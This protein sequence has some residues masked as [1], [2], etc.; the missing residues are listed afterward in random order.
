MAGRASAVL[1]VFVLLASSSGGT[2]APRNVLVHDCAGSCA[3]L[4]AFVADFRVEYPDA[5]VETVRPNEYGKA[6]SFYE[7]DFVFVGAG[8]DGCGNQNEPAFIHELRLAA[9]RFKRHS[10]LVVLIADDHDYVCEDRPISR[11]DVDGVVDFAASV[12]ER[13]T[14]A[15]T[16]GYFGPSVF[17]T[18]T[19]GATE[20]SPF[21][22][23]AL[24]FVEAN[25]HA[26]RPWR[27]RLA[28]I[29]YR[30]KTTPWKAFERGFVAAMKHLEAFY[31][32]SWEN[33]DAYEGVQLANVD[34]DRFN[35]DFDLIFIKSNWG[36]TVDRFVRM[37]FGN[38][39][40]PKAL[41]I[42][43]VA[44]PPEDDDGLFFY[45]TLYYETNWYWPK[46]KRHPRTKKA[47]GIDT[48]VMRPIPHV[49]Q[50]KTIDSLFIG[51][52]ANYKRPW[53]F[54]LH[55]ARRH[56]ADTTP[57]PKLVAIGKL[58]GMPESND[59]VN[60]FKYRG[61]EVR[62]EV[63][64]HELAVLINRAK[65][66]HIPS[67]VLGGGERAVLEARACGVPVKIEE[68]NVK[69][70]ELLEGPI[71]SE[72]QYA[73]A[74]HEGISGLMAFG[75]AKATIDIVELS[76]DTRQYTPGDALLITVRTTNF[77][78]G[79]DGRWCCTVENVRSHDKESTCFTSR[80]G[81]TEAI[82]V[83]HRFAG[84]LRLSCSL[85]SHVYD[86]DFVRGKQ[87]ISLREK[88]VERQS[89]SQIDA[90]HEQIPP[91]RV[92]IIFDSKSRD[93]AEDRASAL[94]GTIQRTLSA[95]GF[96]VALHD[97]DGSIPNPGSRP[98]ITV[99]DP[100]IRLLK[101]Q[102]SLV[103][104]GRLQG[105]ADYF[106]AFSR[107][108]LGIMVPKLFVDVS[109]PADPTVAAA[110]WAK[111]TYSYIICDAP[112]CAQNDHQ[113]MLY[114]FEPAQFLEIM[115]HR[116]L[117]TPRQ[118][119]PVGRKTCQTSR[120]VPRHD[121]GDWSIGIY[122]GKTLETLQPID[123]LGTAANGCKDIAVNPVLHVGDMVDIPSLFVADPFLIF[124]P[125]RTDPVLYMFF[126]SLDMMFRG[127]IGVAQSSD[128]GLSW[129]YLGSALEEQFH[130]SFPYVF[131]DGDTFYMIPESH[132]SKSVRLYSTTLEAFPFGWTFFHTLLSDDFY[133]DSGIVKHGAHW[134]LFTITAIAPN[135]WQQRLYVSSSLTEPFH[136]HP[137]SP[138]T[139][140]SHACTDGRLGGRI[141]Q[142][143]RSEGTGLIRFSQSAE[144]MYGSKLYPHLIDTLSPTHYSEHPMMG[145]RPILEGSGE[146]G[147]WNERLMHH[148]DA[149]YNGEMWIAC[150]DG[151]YDGK[152]LVCEN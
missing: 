8:K 133:Q 31:I 97:L 131:R 147:A 39:R 16:E 62:G 5:H 103:G 22:R 65:E 91:R 32:I 40:T 45:D 70:K 99:S 14:G 64:D 92:L 23:R 34:I 126:E 41:L 60:A 29:H 80:P 75:A 71:W 83:P 118:L 111:E 108:F 141:L 93:A 137:M 46:I 105:S 104:V 6:F 79:F 15:T 55:T 33:L 12:G 151:A 89:H 128:N 18:A 134:Y 63:S 53:L 69:L 21:S 19:L 101:A 113:N 146:H 28:I 76:P 127:Y 38:I 100:T 49:A 66:V 59:V 36:W 78:V 72:K 106:V 114:P 145:G 17:F 2:L 142:T 140:L 124:G 120:M 143:N 98:S 82:G 107:H 109:P 85:R 125:R 87:H 51:W 74:L 119:L 68:D 88:S 102:D 52:M 43:G 117:V 130:L 67:T 56:P 95:N 9:H 129:S 115:Q 26:F 4:A 94:V 27:P 44:D 35:R 144:P 47:F 42:S 58:D 24:S 139:P 48:T 61:V 121:Q 54:G 81:T 77:R 13:T 10:P 138:V 152:G 3:S 112:Q 25:L 116:V 7:W 122:V 132:R 20:G 136:E 11:L 1:A 86:V 37:A 123:N 57:L 149:V 110:E 30:P 50:N 135:A 73:R 150:V 96:L 148:M 90:V 84:E